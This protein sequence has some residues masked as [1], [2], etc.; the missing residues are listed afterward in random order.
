MCA[1]LF[2]LSGASRVVAAGLLTVTGGIG[3]TIIYAK[4][5]HKFRAA[6]EKNVPYS[7]WLLGLALG[8]VSQ[9]A[10]LPIRKPVSSTPPI[11]T[12]PVPSRYCL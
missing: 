4:W 1:P 10:G 11:Y 3:G 5:D 6:V 7:E 2:H 12:V 9:D 8:P